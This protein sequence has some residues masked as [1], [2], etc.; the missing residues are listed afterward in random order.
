MSEI[1]YTIELSIRL[2]PLEDAPADDSIPLRVQLRAGGKRY[3][4]TSPQTWLDAQWPSSVRR[5]EGL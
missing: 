3:A 4:T 2:S 5:G 1:V